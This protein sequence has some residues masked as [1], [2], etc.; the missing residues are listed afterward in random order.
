MA[1]YLIASQLLTGRRQLT[2]D[3]AKARLVH[4]YEQP[5]LE[6]LETRQLHEDG[7]RSVSV[8]TDIREDGT[9]AGSLLVG[10][11]PLPLENVPV[12]KMWPDV[13]VE[14][15]ALTVAFDVS[16]ED[17][18]FAGDKASRGVSDWMDIVSSPCIRLKNGDDV[19]TPHQWAAQHPSIK[20]CCRVSV[21]PATNDKVFIQVEQT[22][23]S[24]SNA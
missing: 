24:L 3:E 19:L 23:L 7:Q 5:I 8:V 17:F 6:S 2:L 1:P 18:T 12:K 20:G 14:H 4:G 21:A 9:V 13:A 10:F 15:R 16:L 11:G 22:N